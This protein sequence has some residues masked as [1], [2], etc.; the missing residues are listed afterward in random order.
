MNTTEANALRRQV[1]EANRTAE[2]ASARERLCREK[3][4][5][6]RRDLNDAKDALEIR[7]QV[8]GELCVECGWDNEDGEGLTQWLRYRLRMPV[9]ERRRLLPNDPNSPEG[10]LVRVGGVGIDA[11]ATILA[12]HRARCGECG[13][14]FDLPHNPKCS[15]FSLTGSEHDG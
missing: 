15:K 8:I 1:R 3:W 5:K 4:R 12:A 2:D 10:R 9:E 7:L 14:H 11:K 13:V 6:D